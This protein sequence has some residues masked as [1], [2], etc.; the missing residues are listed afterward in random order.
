M[1]QRYHGKS[2]GVMYWGIETIR[3]VTPCIDCVL[4]QCCK[5]F[6]R[7]VKVPAYHIG[8]KRCL[9]AIRQTKVP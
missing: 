4:S 3:H 1:E 7:A 9:L 2:I 8:K 6:G 5:F